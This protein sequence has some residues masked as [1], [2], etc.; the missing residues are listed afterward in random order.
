MYY[1]K[2]KMIYISYC[3]HEKASHFLGMSNFYFNFSS[4]FYCLEY[5]KRKCLIFVFIS[6][7]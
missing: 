2:K 6:I 5:R 1:L 4:V 3:A 7:L